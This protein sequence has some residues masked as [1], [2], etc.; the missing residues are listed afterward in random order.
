MAFPE[1]GRLAL[2]SL[3]TMNAKGGICQ[4]ADNKLSA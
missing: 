4:V 1:E 2:G 3:G